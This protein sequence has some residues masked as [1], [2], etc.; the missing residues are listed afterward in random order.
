MY[1][2]YY[3]M[4]VVLLYIL[5]ITRLHLLRIKI[6]EQVMRILKW[7][8][9]W[10]SMHPMAKQDNLHAKQAMCQHLGSQIFFSSW[11]AHIAG[12]KPVP[13]LYRRTTVYDGSSSCEPGRCWFMA[14]RQAT[15]G[16]ARLARSLRATRADNGCQCPEQAKQLS[17]VKEELLPPNKYSLQL[18]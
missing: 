17:N 1:S 15:Q 6:Q 10:E 12:L 13:Y 4:L 9:T 7:T 16:D 5:I 18:N 2:W 11:S 3:F 14:L 8:V